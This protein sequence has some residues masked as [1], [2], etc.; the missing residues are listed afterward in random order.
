MKQYFIISSYRDKKIT[1]IAS[2]F[3]NEHLER[4]ET[5]QEAL[6][7]WQSIGTVQGCERTVFILQKLRRRDFVEKYAGWVFE[8]SPQIGLK[9]FT[10][11]A[12]NS[13][14]DSVGFQPNPSINMEV[15]AVIAF[16]NSVQKPLS[17][18][19]DAKL[20]LTY[21]QEYLLKVCDI[22]NAPEKYF[23]Q[24]ATSLVDALYSVHA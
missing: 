3:L 4:P 6:N 8:V 9:L 18:K 15:D 2:A 7:T 22:P 12:R 17:R 5:L 10:E 14:P 1:R 24:L 11:G 20:T 23:T 16:L 19:P 13:A 21:E